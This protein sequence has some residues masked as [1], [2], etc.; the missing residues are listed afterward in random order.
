V[1]DGTGEA[2]KKR[3]FPLPFFQKRQEGGKRES[4]VQGDMLAGEE[5]GLA[6][7]KR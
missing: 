4:A 7:E 1:D 6:M 5:T 2:A 3:L